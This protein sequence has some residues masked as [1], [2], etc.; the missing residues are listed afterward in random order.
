MIRSRHDYQAIYVSEPWAYGDKPDPE[1]IKA[2]EGVP[3]GRAL[4]LGGGQGRHALA[5]AELGFQVSVVDS[6]AAGLHQVSEAASLRSLS[7]HT[8]QEDAATYE[9]DPGLVVVVAALFFHIPAHKTSL[10]IAMNVGSALEQGGLL[11]V[12]VP[13][14]SDDTCALVREVIQAAECKE[15]WL[16]KHLVTKSERPRLPVPRRNETRALAIKV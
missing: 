13:G 3:R 9:P 12:S 7:V 8:V 16:V 5:L 1:L 6:A 15:E 4:D 11:Y 2:L 14:F 10:N